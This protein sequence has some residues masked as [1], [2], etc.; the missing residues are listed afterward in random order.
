MCDEDRDHVPERLWQHDIALYLPIIQTCGLSSMNL[1]L[2]DALDARPHDLG[3]IGCLEKNKGNEGR[4]KAADGTPDSQ[5]NKK[6]EPEY[7][8]DQRH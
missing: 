8:K 2:F 4:V 3:I 6:E 7:H 1:T 5:R